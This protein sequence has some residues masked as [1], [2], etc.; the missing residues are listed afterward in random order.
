MRRDLEPARAAELIAEMEP[1]EAIDALRVGTT[2]T[3]YDRA[4]P[5]SVSS[6]TGQFEEEEAVL[7][8]DVHD[9]WFEWPGQFRSGENA[10]TIAG[11]HP[12]RQREAQLVDELSMSELSVEGRPALNERV[13]DAA[14]SK[15][16][17]GLLEVHLAFADGDTTTCIGQ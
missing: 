3:P 13:A 2:I 17:E 14:L 15:R 12:G 5:A 1:D 10:G 16:R 7:F 8:E 11:D 4:P 6:D 9:A